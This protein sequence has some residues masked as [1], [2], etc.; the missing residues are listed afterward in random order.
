M[1]GAQW[2]LAHATLARTRPAGMVIVLQCQSPA[3]CRSLSVDLAPIA[4]SLPFG[5]CNPPAE[6]DHPL[7]S[8]GVGAYSRC[9][10]LGLCPVGDSASS[11]PPS[12]GSAGMPSSFGCRG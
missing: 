8:P 9:L 7:A 12:W 1:D 3:Q 4:G 5:D 11:G 2:S 10:E 6:D